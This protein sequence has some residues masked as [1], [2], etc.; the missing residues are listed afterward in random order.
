MEINGITINGGLGSAFPA[1][2]QAKP[3]AP[4][5]GAG[6]FFEELV[7]KVGDLQ[8]QADSKIKGMMT[9]ESREMHE[10]MLAVE[11]ASIS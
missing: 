2:G 11:K 9:G 1:S 10:V 4:S 6:N 5:A 3:A 8:S 7:A